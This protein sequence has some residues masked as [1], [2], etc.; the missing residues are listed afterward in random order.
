VRENGREDAMA[1]PQNRELWPATGGSEWILPGN[2][3]QG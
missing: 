2:G 1:K 3:G